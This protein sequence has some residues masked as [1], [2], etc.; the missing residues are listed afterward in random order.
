MNPSP[1]FE[2]I[3]KHGQVC[4]AQIAA[5]LGLGLSKVRNS[6]SDL[7][8]Q[9]RISC[10]DVTRFENGKPVGEILCRISGFIPPAAPGRKP[11]R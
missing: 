9:G 8:A 5:E 7:L 10:C 3:K 4:D 6:L 1:V 2:H 11:A